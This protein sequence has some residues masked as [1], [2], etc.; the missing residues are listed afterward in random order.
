[1]DNLKLLAIM[2]ICWPLYTDINDKNV[3]NYLYKIKS[4]KENYDCYTGCPTT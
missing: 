4:S 1:M 2:N 3:Y